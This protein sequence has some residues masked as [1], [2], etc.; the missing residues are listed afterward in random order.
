MMVQGKK[1]ICPYCGKEFIREKNA[2][3]YCSERCR[4]RNNRGF[5]LIPGTELKEYT[6]SFCGRTFKWDKKKKYCSLEC[7]ERANGRGIRKTRKPKGLSMTAIAKLA[8]E[9]DLSYGK[10]VAKYGL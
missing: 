8:R 7:R 6:C 1:A 10:Y 4:I 2:Q 5:P 3:K 9:E